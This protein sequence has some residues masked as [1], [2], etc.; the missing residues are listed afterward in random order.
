MDFLVLF[1][2]FLYSAIFIFS[3]PRHFTESSIQAA[4]AH[5]VPAAGLL[6][7]LAG[8]IAFLGGLFVLIG[9]RAREGA[10]LLLLYLAPVT[11]IM[12]GYW[13]IDDPVRADL[14]RMQFLKNLA[15]IGAALMIACLGSGEQS[16]EAW[17][18]RRSRERHGTKI[19]D[20]TAKRR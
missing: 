11:L 15:L 20:L 10:C 14:E 9:Y 3:A 18:K 4:A 19:I 2:R 6:V 12:H 16:F 1:G 8:I 13:F 17:I 5:G 7:P